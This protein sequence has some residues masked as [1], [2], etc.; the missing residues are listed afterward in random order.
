M[1][2]DGL[3]LG[4]SIPLACLS[5]ALCACVT[6]QQRRVSLKRP[7]STQA[8]AVFRTA[9]SYLPE[10]EGNRKPPKDCSDFVGK[11]FAENGI[12]LPRTSLEMSKLGEP[13]ASSKDLSMGDLVFFSGEKI[14][15]AVGHVGIYRSNGIFIH[16]TKPSIGVT[17]ESMYSD[18]YRKRYLKARRVIP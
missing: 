15:P 9:R 5:L 12:K 8:K 3:R 2:I 7:P 18:Y 11:V 17:M 1:D 16:F 4:S 13:I 6:P 10:E 14:G